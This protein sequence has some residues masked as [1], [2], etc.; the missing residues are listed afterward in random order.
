MDKIA[1]F[2]LVT[3]GLLGL[4]MLTFT[5]RSIHIPKGLALIHGFLV[6]T[7]FILLLTYNFTTDNHHKHWQSVSI[8]SVAI[9]AGAYVFWRDISHKGNPKWLVFLHGLVGLTG[10]VV[11]Y[12]H[13]MGAH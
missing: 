6:V 10:I 8:F 5:A 11:L 1:F 7:G 3:G 2:I 13:T 12:F 9:L 4:Y